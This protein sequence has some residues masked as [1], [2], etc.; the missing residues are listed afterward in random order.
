MSDKRLT[1]C[2]AIKEYCISHCN[3]KDCEDIECPLYAFRN[4][5]NPNRKTS[6]RSASQKR[7]AETGHFDTVYNG[8]KKV[9]IKAFSKKGKLRI[10]LPS[11]DEL[12]VKHKEEKC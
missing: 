10:L 2:K 11:G 12:V 8:E 6:T 9:N 3:G 1:P 5:N 7:N 4:A